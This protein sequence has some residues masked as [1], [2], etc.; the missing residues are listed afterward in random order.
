MWHLHTTFI[1]V[2]RERQN[3]D[4]SLPHIVNSEIIRSNTGTGILEITSGRTTLLHRSGTDAS[5]IVPML[6]SQTVSARFRSRPASGES[7]PM[8]RCTSTE[9][10]QAG[11]SEDGIFFRPHIFRMRLRDA[12]SYLQDIRIVWHD[13]ESGSLNHI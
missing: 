5:C 12:I 11:T 7:T 13:Q 2:R 9:H 8:T 6:W 4:I 3:S 10:I 1:I